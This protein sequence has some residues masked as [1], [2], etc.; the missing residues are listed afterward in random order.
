MRTARKKSKK[1]QDPIG[2]FSFF[3][4]DKEEYTKHSK[5]RY[6][7]VAD[8]MMSCN[9]FKELTDGQKLLYCKMR[10]LVGFSIENF[11]V[12][13]NHVYVKFSVTKAKEL[14]GWSENTAIEAFA[15]LEAAGLIECISQ[16][17]GKPYKIF[18]KDFSRP[19]FWR[20]DMKDSIEQEDPLNF[21]RGEA[22]N[23]LNNCSGTPSEIAGDSLK[24]CGGTPSEIE[25]NK[26]SYNQ[27]DLLSN[28]SCVHKE[29]CIDLNYTN[30]KNV[31][32]RLN[33]E[34]DELPS[35]G[36]KSSESTIKEISPSRIVYMAPPSLDLL[37][38]TKAA[39]NEKAHE[40]VAEFQELNTDQ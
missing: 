19:L 34:E 7:K 9:R 28:N 5:F 38:C 35:I 24:N 17:I 16:G 3:G 31:I 13:D 22:A 20:E 6:T 29:D 36:R 18:V 27:S 40:T 15:S 37:F 1:L 23:P 4:P 12:E 10:D 32:T 8:E 33:R 26:L 11:W 30:T 25:D 2:L 14:F 39:K 21:C